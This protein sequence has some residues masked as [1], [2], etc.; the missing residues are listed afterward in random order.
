VS[1]LV[2]VT[3]NCGDERITLARPPLNKAVGQFRRVAMTIEKGTSWT[4]LRSNLPYTVNNTPIHSFA[5]PRLTLQTSFD[6]I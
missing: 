6:N 4:F 1:S 3:A 2:K 5:F